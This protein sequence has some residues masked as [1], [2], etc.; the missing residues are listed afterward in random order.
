MMMREEKGGER[1]ERVRYLPLFYSLFSFSFQ[2]SFSKYSKKIVENKRKGEMR[3]KCKSWHGR[4]M[5]K[6]MTRGEEEK[7]KGDVVI[8]IFTLHHTQYH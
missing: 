5:E 7:R 2:Q 4:R 8:I 3:R 6:R 1:R